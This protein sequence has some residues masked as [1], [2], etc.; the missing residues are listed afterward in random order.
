MVEARHTCITF[1][2]DYIWFTTADTG[3]LITGCIDTPSG[4]TATCCSNNEGE[5]NRIIY[6]T[7]VET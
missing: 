3:H 1:I 2:S 7:V 4:I 6:T 5:F